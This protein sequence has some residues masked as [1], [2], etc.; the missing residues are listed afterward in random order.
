[1]WEGPIPCVQTITSNNILYESGDSFTFSLMM[2]YDISW[3]VLRRK[4]SPP[5]DIRLKLL[6]R[7]SRLQV[8]DSFFL[9]FCRVLINMTVGDLV[10]K[11][12]FK[13]RHKLVTLKRFCNWMTWKFNFY[14]VTM[15]M[16][17]Q[18]YC[19]FCCKLSI[20]IVNVACKFYYS[21]QDNIIL[22]KIK[23]H[24]IICCTK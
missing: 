11:Q 21:H 8:A 13:F 16:D 6:I 2:N 7:K 12:R 23:P 18:I 5:Y 19:K 4:V 9:S 10:S 1:M 15:N 14:L 22:K 24:S 3:S 20:F 17:L